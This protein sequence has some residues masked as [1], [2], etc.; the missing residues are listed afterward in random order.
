MGGRAGETG[1]CYSLKL[2]AEAFQHFNFS[3]SGNAHSPA[4]LPTHPSCWGS[5]RVCVAGC[6]SQCVCGSTGRRLTSNSVTPVAPR[7]FP[8]CNK[9]SPCRATTKLVSFPICYNCNCVSRGGSC[10]SS[11]PKAK[12]PC[13]GKVRPHCDAETPIRPGPQSAPHPVSAAVT[14]GSSISRIS[15]RTALS[16]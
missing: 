5:S 15:T 6:I 9:Q 2:G 4:D 7:R 13:A 14:S 1:A 11:A 8:T 3:E 12:Q 16:A 10:T